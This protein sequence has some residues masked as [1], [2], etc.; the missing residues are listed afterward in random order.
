M[1]KK[2]G[3]IA[4]NCKKHKINA[5]SNNE[6]EYHEAAF[7]ESIYSNNSSKTEK[8]INLKNKI[9]NCLCQINMLTTYQEIL[10]DMINHME[11]KEA[12]TK[13]IRK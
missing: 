4:P 2:K 7:E 6:D 1:W 3:H 11:F 5:I 9:E 10:V 8:A 13:F 12:K